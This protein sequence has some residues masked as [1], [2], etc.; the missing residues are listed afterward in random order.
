MEESFIKTLA[1]WTPPGFTEEI[2]SSKD[3]KRVQDGG[4][5]LWSRALD[6][7]PNRNVSLTPPGSFL[8]LSD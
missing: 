7:I 6:S 4:W 1:I 2:K 5:I 8:I 3:L